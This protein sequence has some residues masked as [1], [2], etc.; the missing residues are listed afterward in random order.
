MAKFV[1]ALFVLC[2]LSVPS[3]AHERSAPKHEEAVK[4][5]HH[6]PVIA[7]VKGTAKAVHHARVHRHMRLFHRHHR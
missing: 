1:C 2:C 4:P 6:Q 7:A 3:V 5:H